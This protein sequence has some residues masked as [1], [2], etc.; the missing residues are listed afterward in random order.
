MLQRGFIIT[1][2]KEDSPAAKAGLQ[3]G[4][5][6]LKINN[7]FFYD[8]LDYQYLSSG[9]RLLLSLYNKKG[10]FVQIRIRKR[11]DED[12]GLE[13]ASPTLGPLL[14]CQNH[15]I[16]CFID[17]QPPGMRSS[18]YEKDDDY[19]LSF[20]YGNYVTLTNLSYLDLKRVIRRGL[21]PLYVSIHST[22]P[23]IRSKMMRNIA[24]GS[25]MEQLKKL[26][27]G[28]IQLHGQ[29]VLCPGYND[30]DALK[31]TIH[32]LSFLYPGLKTVALVP[33]GLTRY[34][35]G[36]PPLQGIT[37][38]EAC[39]IV[40]EYTALQ[41]RFETRWGTPFIYLA[42][43]FY[44]LS[45]NPLP[46]HEHY[47]RYEQIE[48]GVGLGRLFLNELEIWKRLPLLS[49]A[50]EMEISLVTG[51]SGEIFLKAFLEELKKIRGLKTHL[52][53]LPNLFWGGNVTVTGLL[54]GGDLLAGLKG[55][56]LGEAVFIPTVMLK[57]G[58]NLFLDNLSLDFLSS[59]LKV[60]IFPVNS[61]KEIRQ[62]LLQ[63]KF[64]HPSERGEMPFAYTA[65]RF[66]R[67]PQCGK[68]N[69][70]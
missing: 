68:I 18:L 30:K 27:Q 13:F 69:P 9:A 47:G 45:Q 1:K 51:K 21:S 19:R 36:L 40:E 63:K 31:K 37:K 29:I 66:S 58:T 42:D 15:C 2:V 17:Q 48:N 25:I 7:S 14:R 52:H 8:I 54:T 34:R 28:G 11:Y 26:V 56:K 32:D 38:Q 60:R 70:F 3:A 61:I 4:D 22:D 12:L 35:R 67:S 59:Q 53:I 62:F 50:K 49:L 33:V 23:A 20:F 39:R 57:E 6:L 64:T 41:K 16:F 65:R 5:R 44:L 24:A 55:K 10:N 43:E 46:P